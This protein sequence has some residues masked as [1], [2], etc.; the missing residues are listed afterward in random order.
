[1]EVL[2]GKLQDLR[3]RLPIV[4]IERLWRGELPPPQCVRLDAR[5]TL[6][7]ARLRCQVFWKAQGGI[8]YI[9]RSCGRWDHSPCQNSS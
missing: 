3:R 6:D 5:T 7:E 2:G 4:R 1:M 8:G 9:G